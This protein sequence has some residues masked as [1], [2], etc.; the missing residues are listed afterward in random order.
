MLSL[1][2]NEDNQRAQRQGC[3]SIVVQDHY[4]VF[5]KEPANPGFSWI[6][7]LTVSTTT[8]VQ[9]CGACAAEHGIGCVP[10]SF[11][12]L[13][14]YAQAHTL[15]TLQFPPQLGWTSACH[16]NQPIHP[17]Q[18]SSE[19]PYRFIP[20]GIKLAVVRMVAQ[21]HSQSFICETLGEKI[22][23]QS[24]ARW[25]Q[26]YRNTQRVI[27]DPEEYEKRGPGLILTAEDQAFM[28]DLLRLEPGLFLDEMRERLYDQT[29][30]LLSMSSLHSMLVEHLQITL[31]KANTINIKKSLVSKYA[32]VEKMATVPAEFLVF[33]DESCVCSRDLLRTFSRSSKGKPANRTIMQQN[34]KRFTLLPAISV[35]GIV[36]LTVTEENVKGTNFAHF[37]KYC[38]LPRM[39]PYPGP[40]S[41]LVLDN[42][43]IHGGARVARLC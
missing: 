18:E 30:T 36:A 15:Q 37:L 28:I 12:S 9:T 39:N 5:I 41:I 11:A 27:R 23:K 43:G 24:F 13:E 21:S 31:K 38:L 22:S 2:L 42:A 19:M 14:I 26:L 40:K 8:D 34:A 17:S 6:L 10:S 33:T 7:K 20:A 29:D 25:T 32:Y 3:G 4:Y 35:D 1:E 16:T